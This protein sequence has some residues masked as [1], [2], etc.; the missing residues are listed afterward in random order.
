V[1]LTYFIYLILST[2]TDPLDE[3]DE[4]PEAIARRDERQRVVDAL[5]RSVNP[6]PPGDDDSGI[7]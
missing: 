3:E 4:D 2:L 5:C 6:Q 1:S 7:A